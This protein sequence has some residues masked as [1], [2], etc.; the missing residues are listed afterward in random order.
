MSVCP[1]DLNQMLQ[2]YWPK[3]RVSCVELSETRA[4]ATLKL[5]EAN[6]RPGGFISGPA[7]FAVAE[8][9]FWFLVSGAL[10]RVEPMALTSE[11][12]I[13]YLRP[14]VGMDVHSEASLDRLGKKLVVATMRVWAEDPEKLTAV[15]Q[16]TYTLP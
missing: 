14:A 2:E 15:A 5:A 9:A 13:R 10:G 7:Q 16:G 6:L 11:L 12:S 1:E 4:V 8:S 3:A